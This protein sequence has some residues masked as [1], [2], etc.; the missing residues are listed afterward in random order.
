M[1]DRPRREPTVKPGAS[2]NVGLVG[3]AISVIIALVTF[4]VSADNLVAVK[5][6]VGISIGLL[7]SVLAFQL[8][9][10]IRIHERNQ[11]REQRERL[12][13]ILEAE[14]ELLATLVR[15][16][17]DYSR[18]RKGAPL[19]AFEKAAER[20]LEATRLTVAELADGRLRTAAGDNTLMIEQY[21]TATREILATSDD[22]DLGWWQSETG[23]N[24]LEENRR[25]VERGVLVSRVFLLAV[26]DDA[27]LLAVMRANADAGV[28]VSSARIDRIPASLRINTTIF[29][30]TLAHEDVTNKAGQTI[31]YLYSSNENDMAR[32]VSSFRRLQSLCTPFAPHSSSATGG[33]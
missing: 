28:L 15:T 11:S 26:E 33:Q 5:A 24:Y 18:L 7:G 32:L 6:L 3:T 14:P 12:I 20:M 21:R 29:D 1:P 17:Q 22:G 27:G 19:P 25:A 23:R 16:A 9:T 4:L 2:K 30:D 8:E 31:S 13:E 10:L